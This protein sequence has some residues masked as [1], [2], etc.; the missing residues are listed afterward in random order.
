MTL[1]L[2]PYDETSEWGERIDELIDRI[3]EHSSGTLSSERIGGL[4]AAGNWWLVDINNGQGLAIV[5]PLHFETGKKVLEIIGVAGD[6]MKEWEGAIHEL[7]FV[8]RKLGYHRIRAC[9]R[10]GWAK[11]AARHGYEVTRVV[12][13]KDLFD[14]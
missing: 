14:A 3:A 13:E 10:K 8:A 12:V 9:G 1:A 2:I 6:D 5:E 11:V 7:E 4:I